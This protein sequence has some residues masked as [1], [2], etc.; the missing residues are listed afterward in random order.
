[1]RKCPY[2][3]KTFPDTVTMCPTDM[4][5]LLPDTVSDMKPSE[6][7]KSSTV[8]PGRRAGFRAA[9]PEPDRMQNNAYRRI[10]PMEP[11]RNTGTPSDISPGRDVNTHGASPGQNV[12]THEASVAN[13]YHRRSTIIRGPAWRHAF[14]VLRILLPALLI[15][16]AVIAITVNWG[17]I[18]PF[19]TCLVTGAILGG[20]AGFLLAARFRRDSSLDIMFTGVIV[21]AVLA[22]L[23]R[24]NLL[25]VGTTLGELAYPVGCIVL[26]IYGLRMII[27][28]GLR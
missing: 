3:N 13:G 25:D 9:S 1:M 17:V 24:Y 26:M 4:I 12:N 19:L 23:I 10:D 22:C 8:S 16:A 20:V 18:R 21:G 11:G 27:R 7:R 5:R 2:C 14:R 28:A 6:N 15:L